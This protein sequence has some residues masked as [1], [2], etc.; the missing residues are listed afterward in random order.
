MKKC[1]I[2]TNLPKNLPLFLRDRVMAHGDKYLHAWKDKTG[3]FQYATYRQVYDNIIAFA[4]ALE[5]LGVRAGNNIG[6]IS[7][8]RK[9]WFITSFAIQSLGCADVPRG[10]DSLGTEIRFILSF[11]DCDMAFLENEKQLLKVLENTAEVPLLKTVILYDHAS[12]ETEQKTADAGFTLYYFDELLA[13][14]RAEFNA[15]PEACT[16]RIEEKM[17]QVPEDDTC[18]I[19]FTSGTT[20]TPKGVMLT[21]KNFMAQMSAAHN[22]VPGKPGEMWMSILPIWHSFERLAMYAT[23]LVTNCIA[24]SKPIA[25]TLLADMAIIRPHRMCGVPRL[26]EALVSGINQTMQKKGGIT[27]KL[28]NYFI[29]VGKRYAN[30]RDLVISNVFSPTE[31]NAF[32][33]F[34]HG[35]FPFL[36]LAPLHALGNLLVYRKIK[37]RF[38]GRIQYVV[39]GGGSLQKDTDDFFRAIGIPLL[40]AYGM[41]ETA[42][43]MAFRD[44]KHPQTNCIGDLFPTLEFKVVREEQG[45]VADKTPLPYGQKGLILVRGAN[46]MKGYYKRP[47]LT[48]A[49]IDEDGFLNTGD[50]GIISPN[51][52]LAITGRAKDTIVLLGGENIEPVL[53]EQTICSSELIESAMVVGQDKKY[54]SSLIVPCKEKLIAYAKEHGIIYTT[55]ESLLKNEHIHSLIYAA[56]SKLVSLEKGFR[57]CEKIYKISLIA[58][59][60]EVGKEL[61]AKQEMMR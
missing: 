22:F 26:W 7:D 4:L 40:N 27:W 39:C 12:A 5:H 15:D 57:T 43:G 24:Y 19:I 2:N 56:V 16:A 21:H 38:G 3:T 47:D 1:T 58:K 59:S 34:M 53:I 17:N 52:E 30:A 11:A 55:Y 25:R 49:I 37:E 28:F 50:I 10:C 33:D 31:R 32:A 9:E 13:Q 61:S 35:I 6:I 29:D 20:G 51:R 44:L 45:K 23:I 54:L 42:P 60:F 18:T 48:A 14:S 41:T 46:V 36:A 8:N